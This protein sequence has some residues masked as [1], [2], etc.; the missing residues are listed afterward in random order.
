MA[1]PLYVYEDESHESH[2]S[3]EKSDTVLCAAVGTASHQHV[4]YGIS[5]TA[6]KWHSCTKPICTKLAR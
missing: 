4:L 1:L 6:A 2:D 3:A 5:G